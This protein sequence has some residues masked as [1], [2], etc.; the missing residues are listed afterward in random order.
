M[1]YITSDIHG[2][3][4]RWLKLRQHLNN[5]GFNW[6]QDRIYVLGDVI[7]RGNDSIALLKEIMGDQ[8]VKMIIGNHEYAFISRLKDEPYWDSQLTIANRQVNTIFQYNKLTSADQQ[9]LSEWLKQ[10][11]HYYLLDEELNETPT[12][13]EAK[14]V[15]THAPINPNAFNEKKELSEYKPQELLESRQIRD[16]YYTDKQLIFGHIPTCTINKDKSCMIHIGSGYLDIDCGCFLKE[17][18]LACICIKD[19][20]ENFKT[21]YVR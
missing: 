5:N 10:L 19:N 13:A 4:D 1:V 7:D 8:S 3:L 9:E 11:P 20:S 15:L 16:R 21:I 2:R 14:Y 17:G 6:E 12:L 18:A